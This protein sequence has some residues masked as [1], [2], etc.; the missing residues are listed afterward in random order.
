[1]KNVNRK[2]VI[3][4]PA[5]NA[6]KTIVKTYKDIPANLKEISSIILV[7]DKSSD[8]TVAIA[9]KLGIKVFV[10]KNNLG[11]G[12][13]QK[14]CYRNALKLKPDIIVMIHPDYQYDSTLANEL[15][16]PLMDGWLDIMLGSRIRT[17]KEA[18]ESGM[19]PYK[20]FSNRFLT[21]IEN[22]FLGLNLGEYHTGF[23]AYK[24]DVLKNIPFEMFSNDF[25]FD[26]ELL[27]SA[28]YSRYRIGEI[29]IP[30]RYFPE[31]SS[32][33]FKRGVVYGLE[34]LQCLGKYLLDK[35]GL[36]RSPIFK[37]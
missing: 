28:A 30:A 2:V 37:H 19:A 35:A 31:A 22:I 10:H 17:R 12:G 14:T 11:Y 32:Q 16:R 6:E 26:Q 3:V 13:N 1:M 18:L 29:S 4:M 7:D 27:I 24:A 34:T 36:F 5:Y 15:I 33:N 9:K 20:Y 8:K 25:V 23:R 21:L